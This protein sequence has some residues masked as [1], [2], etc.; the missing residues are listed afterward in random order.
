MRGRFWQGLSAMIDLYI[1]W[2]LWSL[3]ILLNLR[4]S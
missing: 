3:P 2:H 1:L 4:F